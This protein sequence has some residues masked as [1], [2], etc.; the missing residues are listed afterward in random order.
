MMIG[1]VLGCTECSPTEKWFIGT[2]YDPISGSAGM[3]HIRRITYQWSPAL[4]IFISHESEPYNV[5]SGNPPPGRI[6][7]PVG[8]EMTLIKTN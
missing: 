5:D 1:K 3:I 8:K 7:F 2:I 4:K 6:H